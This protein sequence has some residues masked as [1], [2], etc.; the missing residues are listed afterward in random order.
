LV[1]ILQREIEFY[2]E[3]FIIFPYECRR[4][5]DVDGQLTIGDYRGNNRNLAVNGQVGDTQS[6]WNFSIQIWNDLVFKEFLGKL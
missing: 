5:N 2:Y 3:V 6:R 4:E 1:I